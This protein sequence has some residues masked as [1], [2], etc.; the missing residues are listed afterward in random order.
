MGKTII[1][2]LTFACALLSQAQTR[3][4]MGGVY[5]AYPT[6][7]VETG[8]EVP[9]AMEDDGVD[10]FS[11][12]E[13]Y[14]PFYISHYGR[15]GSRW[16]PKDSRYIWV[17]QHFE[18]NSNLTP[19]G[20]KVKKL[21]MRVWENA[22]GNG[23]KLSKL[24]ELQHRGIAERMFQR[25]PQIFAAGNHVQAR[26]SVVDRCAKSMLAFTD[27]L[28]QLQ[29]G[30]EVDVK[31]DSA[32]MAWIAY[33]S[34]EVKA[35]ENR[36]KVMANV[37]AK[38]FMRQ[39]FKDI[40][41]VDEPMKLMGEI[42]T[43][44]SSMQDV[45]LNFK[46][47]PKDIEDRLNELFTDEEFRA[48]YE[49]N[50]R[51]MT[52]CNG[53]EST[54]EEIPAR[55][56]ISLWKNIV[57]EADK[58]LASGKPSATLRFG[59]DTS[60]YRLLSLLN[61][62][63]PLYH[64][65]DSIPEKGIVLVDN[66]DLMNRVVPMAANL[67]MV[68]YK[69]DCY[70][71]SVM[72][73]FI[74][75]GQLMS[76]DMSGDAFDGHSDACYSWNHIKAYM[77]N[78]IHNLEHIRQL[79]ALNTMVGTA[80]ANT[81]TA[82]KF[83]KGSEEHGQ[84]LPAVLVPNGQN[85]WTP[86]TQDTEKKCIAPYYYKDTELQGF[87]NSH[88]I[89]GGC[90]QDYGS[91][92]VAT[93]GGKLR[94]QPEERATSF[95]HE[96]EISHPHYYAV[97]LKAE[98]L[99]TELAALSHVA[100]LRVTPLHDENIH[101]VVNPNSDEGEGYIEI[102]TLN[103]RVY[104]Y[105]P[106][107]RIYQGWGEPAG[108]SGHFVLQYPANGKLV[109]F[110]VFS[111]DTKSEKKLSTKG[112]RIG[113][114]L[115][116]TGISNQKIEFHTVSSFT[117]KENAINN[118]QTELADGDFDEVMARAQNLWCERFHTIDVESYDTAKVNQFYG[119]MYRASFLPREMSDVN[120]DYPQFANGELKSDSIRS[121]T[122]THLNSS[123]FT[124]HSS[125]PKAYG[126]FSM[127]DIY[128]AELPLYNI[129][130]PKMS[131]DMMQSLVNMYKEGG[132][133][134]IFPCWNDYTAAM[135]GDHASVALADAYI[136]G[137]MNFEVKTAYKGMRMNAF[138]SPKT[139]EEYKNGM[140]RR[141]LK[142]YLKYG[143]IPMEDSVKEA[144]HQNEQTSRTLEYA[145]DDFAV[146]QLA[147]ALAESI[148][149]VKGE[150]KTVE[151]YRKALLSDYSALMHRSEN[152]CNVINPKT[153]WAD[154]RHQ[155]GQWEGNLDLV[156]RKSYITE[157]ATCHYTWYVPQ[158]VEGLFH[159]VGESKVIARLDKMFD[160]GLYWHGNEPC[161]Q[162]AYLY[163]AAGAPWK[164]QE[165]VH[166]I[167]NTEYNDTP[168]GLSGNDDAGQ[169][170]AWYMFSAIGFYPVC[171]S[172]PYYYI[173]APSFDKVTFNLE[174]GEKF[175]ITAEGV[176]DK[177]FYVQEATLNGTPLLKGIK[178][179]DNAGCMDYQLTHEDIFMGGKLHFVMGTRPVEK[180]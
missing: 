68:F 45:G 102:D 42:H 10:A 119:S 77:S 87:R 160:E 16:M 51:R 6:P 179:S 21:L 80:Q 139:F 129:I 133:L 2:L 174:N 94:L 35:L 110:G 52:I 73:K 76:F 132:W 19:L 171:P 64:L 33:T 109:G 164:T 12:P 145:F 63:K 20:K 82:G 54:N 169:M 36:T 140:G 84:T 62:V 97:D 95:S 83:G 155:N 154:G 49:A 127:W 107:H 66:T 4:Q 93:L 43:I 113:A 142:S 22:Q 180:K 128:R 125:L 14:A 8:K 60:L 114:W 29:P 24:G 149:R 101:I 136:K 130:A 141:A 56:A 165:R 157:G 55:S 153:G 40:S 124:P 44:A 112:E 23:G 151:R 3:R 74:L 34:P 99:K 69:S 85:F 67:Q 92:T 115:T 26:S 126:D 11:A 70:A 123:L 59:H 57:A 13:G 159:V 168:G 150:D 106:V 111:K 32:D 131:G 100:V 71:D 177:A 143:Y 28:R 135:I 162:V 75:N 98:H 17:N 103:H 156:H 118:L 7:N 163:D 138:E 90:T 175:E 18:D 65:G 91:F 178:R 120:G 72:V 166:H 170:S 147:K 158:N 121:H 89:V 104:G 176:S 79:N 105:N 39:L 134:P 167:L 53:N 38:R 78:R 81:Q 27:E 108:F 152:W 161:H 116:F 41:K 96:D 15:H 48:F 37:S 30:L 9:H 122:E 47:Y 31:T 173:G 25:F 137:V 5:C 172:T 61:F 144:F 1:F 148:P 86:Q 88:W 58:A 117:S 146:A 50:N 46:R